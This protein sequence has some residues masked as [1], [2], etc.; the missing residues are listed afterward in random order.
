MYVY[1]DKFA[2]VVVGLNGGPS[3]RCIKN[4]HSSAEAEGVEVT[5]V[6]NP[7]PHFIFRHLCTIGKKGTK[8]K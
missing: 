6:L 1:E 8:R 4:R 2:K 3:H 7:Q 5:H